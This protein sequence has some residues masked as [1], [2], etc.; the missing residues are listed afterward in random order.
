[1]KWTALA[2]AY[3]LELV[4]LWAQLLAVAARAAEA[5]ARLF[6]PQKSAP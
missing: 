6:L 1:M 3:P 5:A 4:A 2:S